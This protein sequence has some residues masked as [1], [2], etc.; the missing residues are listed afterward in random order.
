MDIPVVYS[1]QRRGI[2]AIEKGAAGDEAFETAFGA[3]GQTEAAGMPQ[4]P[5]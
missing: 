5:R 2:V 1:N 3:W 4:P